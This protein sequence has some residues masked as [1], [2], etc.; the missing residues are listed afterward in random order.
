[1]CSCCA[2]LAND[3][4]G[5]ARPVRRAIH[6]PSQ[7]VSRGTF[8]TG[9]SGSVSPRSRDRWGASTYRHAPT[10]A[11]LAAR[12]GRGDLDWP[13]RA[14][15]SRIGSGCRRG[16]ARVRG[17]GRYARGSTPGDAV[18]ARPLPCT[19]AIG[20]VRRR[21]RRL[22][23]AREDPVKT[24]PVAILSLLCVLLPTGRTL[25]ASSIFA[26]EIQQAPAATDTKTQAPAAAD[27]KQ[28]AKAETT[29][30]PEQL[31]QIVAPIALHPDSLLAQILMAS[32]YPLEIVEAHRWLEKNPSLKD[33]QLEEALKKQDWDPAV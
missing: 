27:P 32:T 21:F 33:K 17:P 28:A 25:H 11:P 7:T 23:I 8:A 31:E 14:P 6:E 9:R 29:F 22:P 19:A 3:T 30:K 4:G 18:A 13:P 2:S 15:V 10:P 16:V 1:M 5:R 12:G 20:Y 24:N 26:F